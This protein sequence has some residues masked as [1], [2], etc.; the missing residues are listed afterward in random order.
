MWWTLLILALI[1][2]AS[3]FFVDFGQVW[4]QLRRADLRLMLAAAGA[5]LAGLLIYAAR[6]HWLLDGQRGWR[7]VFHAANIGHVV[8]ILT[9]IRAGE[10]IRIVALGRGDPAVLAAVTGSVLVERLLEQIMR[11]VALGGAIAFGA[12][13]A[14]SPGSAVGGLGLLAGAGVGI[15]W[16]V[17][18][19]DTVLDRWPSR[20]ARLPRLKP[21]TARRALAGLLDNLGFIARPSRLALALGWTLLIW[22]CWAAFYWLAIQAFDFGLAPE[23]QWAV[24]LGALALSPPS[25]PAMFGIYHASVTVPLAAVGFDETLLVAFTVLAHALEMLALLPLGLWGLSGSEITV[26]ELLRRGGDGD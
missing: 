3:L 6:W 17:N 8:N 9:P 16:M 1:L 15:T 25:A 14:V 11:F 23:Q 5:L 19:R 4:D 7:A 2:V 26:G 21:A 10:P 18:N 12:G 13:L 22:A 20:L 24:V